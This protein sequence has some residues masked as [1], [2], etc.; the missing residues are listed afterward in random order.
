MLHLGLRSIV[1]LGLAL[2]GGACDCQRPCTSPFS[3]SL[4]V[5][6]IFEASDMPDGETRIGIRIGDSESTFVCRPSEAC[7]DAG[8]GLVCK[9]EHEA[10]V[11]ISVTDNEGA[12]SGVEIEVRCGPQRCRGPESVVV[13]V[14]TPTA[15]YME[16]A[17][18]D[19]VYEKI[20]N[21]CGDRFDQRLVHELPLVAR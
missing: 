7:V 21:E 16:V 17:F 15:E 6:E 2:V 5:P 3:A 8:P 13:N 10:V 18:E 14:T 20:E 12:V 19:L 1:L 9:D 4:V 11:D